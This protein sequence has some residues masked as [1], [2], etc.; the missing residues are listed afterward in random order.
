[1]ILSLH[2]LK[3]KFNQSFKSQ[4]AFLFLEKSKIIEKLFEH[5]NTHAYLILPL[6]FLIT[7][8]KKKEVI[9]LTFYGLTFWLLL[10]FYYDIPR[11]I[12]KT[13]YQPVYTSLE[14][15]YF[16]SLFYLQL[17]N[18]KFRRLIVI[19]SVFFIAFQIIYVLAFEKGRLDSIPIGIESILM[20]VY[21]SL[22]FLE[23]LK[24]PST[25]YIYNN[26]LFWISAGLLFYL[27]GSFFI[28]ILANS[29]SNEEFNKYWFLS[30]IADTIKT[31]LF[32][33][34]FISIVR[35][36]KQSSKSDLKIP[37]LDMI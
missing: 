11:E 9:I 8:F 7:R 18:K 17:E 21:I 29:F 2:G 3:I 14:Y 34:A 13:I 23:Y 30:Y 15:L 12:K 26:Y 37:H 22:F 19:L 4:K 32:A 28:N 25:E 10:F 24:K 31:L 33:V 20:F 16:T 6:L 35:K 27:G 1:L 36:P 5:I